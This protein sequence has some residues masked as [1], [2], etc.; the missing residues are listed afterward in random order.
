MPTTGTPSNVPLLLVASDSHQSLSHPVT[1]PFTQ[2]HIHTQTEN[3]ISGL[4]NVPAMYSKW[5]FHAGSQGKFGLYLGKFGYKQ[6]TFCFFVLCSELVC[7]PTTFDWDNMSKHACQTDGLADN[8][9]MT[10]P[11]MVALLF[12]KSMFWGC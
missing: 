6:Y 2:T 9:P 12:P 10:D 8:A 7:S 1:K 3:K 11:Q 5:S 4:R